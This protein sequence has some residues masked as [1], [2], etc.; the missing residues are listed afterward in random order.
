MKITGRHKYAVRTTLQQTFQC[1]LGRANTESILIFSVSTAERSPLPMAAQ[2]WCRPLY[3]G[4]VTDKKN[5]LSICTAMFSNPNYLQPALTVYSLP[6]INIVYTQHS[7]IS[8]KRSKRRSLWG[9]NCTFIVTIALKL[10]SGN[11]PLSCVANIVVPCTAFWSIQQL[12]VLF[13]KH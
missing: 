9:T 2:P 13:P 3:G 7:R 1:Q 12:L 6:K 10:W 4:H 5:T 8:H 11:M